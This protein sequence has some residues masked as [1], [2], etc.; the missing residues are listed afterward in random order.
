MKDDERSMVMNLYFND[1]SDANGFMGYLNSWGFHVKFTEVK[2]TCPRNC[3]SLA[4]PHAHMQ[5]IYREDYNTRDN[6]LS[7]AYTMYDTQLERIDLDDIKQMQMFEKPP[8]NAEVG[9]YGCHIAS[10][11]RH[12]EHERNK[13]KKVHASW[14]FHQYFDGL[15][16]EDNIPLVL[17]RPE[18]VYEGAT[19]SF[20]GQ[21]HILHRIVVVM[22]FTS[23][24]GLNQLLPF[25]H[26]GAEVQSSK[27]LRTYIHSPDPEEMCGF[28]KLKYDETMEVW[29][30]KSIAERTLPFDEVVYDCKYP[31]SE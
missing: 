26:D 31:G 30:N 6:P 15:V 17:V 2:V 9:T 25:L 1:A 12:P 7:P 22:D 19:Y 3:V 8:A 24:A 21:D 16:T 29:D 13:N 18:M 28:F 11:K 14:L 5:R 10:R 20:K 23:E 4:I 27:R